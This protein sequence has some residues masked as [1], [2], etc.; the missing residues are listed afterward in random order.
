MVM[1]ILYIVTNRLSNIWH[2]H[3]ILVLIGGNERKVQIQI[4]NIYSKRAHDT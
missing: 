1:L 2:F 4:I 3:L